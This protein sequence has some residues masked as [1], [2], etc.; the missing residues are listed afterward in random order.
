VRATAGPALLLPLLQDDVPIP[1]V[2]TAYEDKTFEYVRIVAFCRTC[3][4]LP[5]GWYR[6][7][8]DSAACRCPATAQVMKTPPATYFIKKA[9]GVKAG[10]Q[11]PGH[12]SVASISLK[13]IH[14][15]AEVKQKDTPQLG[16]PAVC[17]GL[18]G[19]CRSM[20]IKV[21]ARPEDAA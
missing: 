1:V 13:H 16:L 21:V 20:G 15:I 9:A 10:S 14:A 17:Q 6:P 8:A 7:A 19:T 12:E 3:A 2:I 18:I 5:C 11:K 4:T